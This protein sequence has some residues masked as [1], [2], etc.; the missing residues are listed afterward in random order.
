[1]KHR[2]PI[3]QEDNMNID[4]RKEIER[5]LRCAEASI[6]KKMSQNEKDFNY[7]WYSG[8]LSLLFNMSDDLS[9]KEYNE[10][11]KKIESY[12]YDCI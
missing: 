10:I 9:K 11:S 4:I 5:V 7:A 3:G 12:F 8:Q 2:Q 1:M 6:D